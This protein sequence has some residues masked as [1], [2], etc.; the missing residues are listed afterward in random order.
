[1]AGR[2]HLHSD[3]RSLATSHVNSHRRGNFI[4]LLALLFDLLFARVAAR[5]RVSENR[6]L[7]LGVGQKSLG[8]DRAMGL[9]KFL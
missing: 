3:Y 2:F 5:V 1:L 6:L 4:C 8:L 9:R 7:P